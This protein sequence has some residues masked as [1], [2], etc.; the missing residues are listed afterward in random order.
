MQM[1]RLD[2]GMVGSVRGECETRTNI[3]RLYVGEI[4]QNLSFSC[5]MRTH[6]QNIGH[7]HTRPGNNRPAAADGGIGRDTGKTGDLHETN[8]R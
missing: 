2:A 1:C 6:F 7:A 4:G 8:V 5:A 3:S